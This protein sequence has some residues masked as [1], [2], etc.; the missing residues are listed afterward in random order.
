M[1]CEIL[2]IND[3]LENLVTIIFKN[4]LEILSNRH[5]KGLGSNF[6]TNNQVI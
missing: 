4:D 2:E 5:W 6:K 3:F 1:L